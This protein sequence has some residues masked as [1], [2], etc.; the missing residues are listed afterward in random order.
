MFSIVIPTYH[1]NEMLADCLSRIAPDVQ[2]LHEPYEVLVTDDGRQ[3]TA[4][5]MLNTQYSWVKWV[6]GPQRGPAS[7]RNNGAKQAQ[8]NWIV[9]LDDDC[10][11]DANLLLAYQSAIEAAPQVQVWE[12][13]IYADR[14]Q[15]RFDEESPI[16]LAG[17]KLWSC[18][19]CIQKTVFEQLNGFDEGFPHATMEDIDLRI[20]LK[21]AGF[22]IRFAA[23]AAVCHPW[24]RT[25]GWAMYRKRLESYQ[26]FINKYPEKKRL[27]TPYSRVKILIGRFLEGVGQLAKFKFKGIS[28]FFYRTWIDVL[29][30][31]IK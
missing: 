20:R 14:R 8:G 25:K 3:S 29:L 24:R 23:D 21:D 12:G 7:N 26:Y 31:F 10:L 17:G 19:F 27:H 11:P 18:N 6:Q 13:K 30:I 4:Q 28:N 16:N 1:R 15:E 5:A 9:F 2:Q 22:E